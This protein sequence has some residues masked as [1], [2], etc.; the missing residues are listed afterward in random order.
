MTL[1]KYCCRLPALALTAVLLSACAS[2]VPEAIR[3]APTSE[4]SIRAVQHSPNRY[5]DNQVRWGG[6][7]IAIENRPNETW[8]EVLARPLG[9]AGEPNSSA[10]S[11]GRFLARVSSFL[12]PAVYTPER[13][14]TVRGR[15][16]NTLVR[17]IGGHPYRFPLVQVQAHYLWPKQPE[18][19]ELWN[20]PWYPYPY[21]Y[22][23]FYGPYPPYYWEPY[24][25]RPRH[26]PRH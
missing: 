25:S 10:N 3:M 24:F 26:Y 22:D 2:H 1:S 19:D 6:D 21:G 20:D 23:P 12:D 4:I 18:T 15:L 14:I 5:I 16:E 7:I 17:Q 11:N 8:I 9:Y 13:K